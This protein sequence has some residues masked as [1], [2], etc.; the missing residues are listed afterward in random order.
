MEIK[1]PETKFEVTPLDACSDPAF[2]L[3]DMDGVP[4]LKK[5][6]GYYDQVQGQLGI[7]KA[8]WCDFV[9][10]TDKELSIERLTLNKIHWTELKQRLTH[11]YFEYF[12]PEAAKEFASRLSLR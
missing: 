10:Y 3:E 11:F 2:Y 5:S 9:V 1:C 6:H 8:K 12:L 4:T 7:T